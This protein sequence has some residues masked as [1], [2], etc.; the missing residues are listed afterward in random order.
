MVRR[1]WSVWGMTRPV[2][3]GGQFETLKLDLFGTTYIRRSERMHV[4][5]HTNA[6]EQLHGRYANLQHIR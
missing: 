2:G 1:R 5:K 4:F 3:G 6:K